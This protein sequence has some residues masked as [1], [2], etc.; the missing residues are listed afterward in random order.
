MRV[1]HVARLAARW[2][3]TVG[4]PFDGDEASRAWVAPAVRRDGTGAAL[5]LGM[6]HMEA[7]HE[8]HALRFWDGDGAIRVLDFD[9]DLNAKGR[10]HFRALTEESHSML[11]RILFALLLVLA[12][13]STGLAADGADRI[14][15]LLARYQELGLFNGSALVAERGQVVMKKGYGLANMEWGIPNA[16][17]TKFRIGSISKQFTATLVIRLERYALSICAWMMRSIR[18]YRTAH[19]RVPARRRDSDCRLAHLHRARQ[20]D[21]DDEIRDR[22]RRIPRSERDARGREFWQDVDARD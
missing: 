15:A 17:D 6:P 18:R 13:V 9:V 12:N 8:L 21:G 3:L 20:A 11:L 4:A 2:S 19:A 22:K 10:V 1:G 7:A 16:A 14:D 5:K